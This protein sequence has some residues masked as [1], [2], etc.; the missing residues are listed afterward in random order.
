MRPSLYHLPY[1]ISLFKYATPWRLWIFLNE[2]MERHCVA[3]ALDN[4]HVRFCV[5]V[6][7][8]YVLLVIDAVWDRN[9]SIMC[10]SNTVMTMAVLCWCFFVNYMQRCYFGPGLTNSTYVNITVSLLELKGI[11]GVRNILKLCSKSSHLHRVL[12]K[13]AIMVIHYGSTAI[14]WSSRW[15][16]IWHGCHVCPAQTYREH[17][18]YVCI[19]CVREFVGVISVRCSMRS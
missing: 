3:F 2:C 14:C 17:S 8:R 10:C 19:P 12:P 5:F 7:S 4:Q 18:A 11:A 16:N 9:R 13:Y 1:A 15:L 6:W